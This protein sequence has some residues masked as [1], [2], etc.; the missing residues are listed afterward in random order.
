MENPTLYSPLTLRGLE[1]RNRLFL[2]PMCQYSAVDGLVQPWHLRHYAERAVGGVGLAL[3]E[4]TAV[5]PAGRITPADLGLWNDA[6]RDALGPLVA[7]VHAAGAKIGVQL[8][9]AGRKASTYVPWLGSGSVVAEQGGWTTVSCTDQ[10]FEGY[11]APRSLDEAGLWAVIASFA[12]AARRAVQAGF[13]TVELHGA[14]GYLVHQFLSPL[15][16]TRTDDWGGT[17]DKRFRFVLEVVRAIRKEVPATFPVL[18]RVSATDWVEGGWT[19]EETI[20]LLKLLKAEGVDFVDVSSGGLVPGAKI[21]VGPGYQVPLAARIRRET[22]L[23]T[24]TVGLITAV[25]QAEKILTAGE[26]DAI[27]MGRQLLRDPYFPL[28]HAP[29]AKHW[30]PVQYQRAF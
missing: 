29:D 14:H 30:A 17:R 23:A 16:N 20:E 3:V 8:A 22:G 26:A 18:I 7:A 19:L 2:S 5:D 11:S 28:R 27:L 13:D 10:P 6:Q 1:V 12:A 21:P 9:H 24:G 4:A 15:T 25:D